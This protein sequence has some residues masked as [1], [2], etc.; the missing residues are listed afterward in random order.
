MKCC[1]NIFAVVLI[2]VLNSCSKDRVLIKEGSALHISPAINGMT[3]SLVDDSNVSTKEIGVQITDQA[4]TQ[5]YDGNSQ[6]SNLRLIKP[7]DSWIFDDGAGDSRDVLLNADNAKIY[8]YYPYTSDP[9]VFTGTANGAVLM[10]DIPQ[11]HSYGYVQDYL[12]SA[13]DKTLPTGGLPI[14][15]TSSSVQLKMNHALA[16]VAFVFYK[17]GYEGTGNIT[18]MEMKSLSAA[19]VFI[20]NK[21]GIND[22]RMKLSNGAFEGGSMVPNLILTDINSNIAL[23]ADPGTDAQTLF[24]IRNFH[25]LLIP[26]SIAAREDIEFSFDID[27]SNYKVGFPG[28]GALNMTAGNINIITVKLSPKSLSITGVATWNLVEYEVSSGY[29]DLWYGM[30]PVQIGSLLWA[31]VNEGYD[32]ISKPYGLLYQWHRKYGQT[33]DEVPLPNTVYQQV[34]LIDGNSIDNRNNYY[35]PNVSPY[36]WMLIQQGSWDMSFQYNPCPEGWRV[37]NRFELQ[38]LLA[39]GYSYTLNGINGLQGI[40]VGGNYNT[41]LDGSIFFP[42]GGKRD[43]ITNTISSRDVWGYYW[44]THI[45]DAGTSII[46]MINKDGGNIGAYMRAYGISVRCVKDL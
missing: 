3:K 32:P 35:N 22:L 31:P 10:A 37:P 34:S 9:A 19:N 16:M 39:T 15:S 38:N 23:T 21:T 36:D 8:A 17:S 13:Q 1:L 45:N 11:S 7:A 20:V 4:G 24:N 25:M 2:L 33:Y 18:A 43:P 26:A 14:N 41:D 46:L 40:W 28:S 5:L 30:K 44:S 27:G 6:Y 12:W 42:F 29:D